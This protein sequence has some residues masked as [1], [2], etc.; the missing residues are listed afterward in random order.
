M[1]SAA[2]LKHGQSAWLLSAAHVPLNQHPH[3]RWDEWPSEAHV[4]TTLENVY[5]LPLFSS[6]PREPL[7][8]HVRGDGII[9]DIMALPLDASAQRE[10]R[11]FRAF[12]VQDIAGV[13]DGDVIEAFGYPLTAP[14]PAEAVA[15]IGAK[16][17]AYDHMLI[18]FRPN[19]E[20]GFS[21]GPVLNDAGKLVG[22]LIGHDDGLGAA[23][24]AQWIAHD[25]IGLAPS[26]R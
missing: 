21:G 24:S 26:S 23:V 14:W 2:I 18:R 5:P 9:A 11:D 15:R 19:A 16:V 4:Y 17:V 7:F 12:E 22:I 10:L 8:L 1:G 3:H 13:S 6:L 25:L 20:K